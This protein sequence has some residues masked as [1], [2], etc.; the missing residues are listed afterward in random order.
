MVATG[1]ALLHLVHPQHAGRHL[2]SQVQGFAQV[3]FGLAE[4]LVVQASKI[5]TQQRQPPEPGHR[6]GRQAL[7][8]ALHT[9]QQH[10]FRRIDALAFEKAGLPLAEPALEIDQAADIGETRGVVLEAEHTVQIQ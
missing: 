7:A 2:L 5:Q 4:E 10:A 8:T 6:L 1:Q 3:A 9:D